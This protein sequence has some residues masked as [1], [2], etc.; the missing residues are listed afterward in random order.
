ML[1]KIAKSTAGF[2][3]I[4]QDSNKGKVDSVR[5]WRLAYYLR[6][7]KEM[8]K[9]RKYGR[10]FAEEIIEEYRQ[11]VVHNLTGRNKDNNIRNI[12][13]IPVATRL[14]EMETKV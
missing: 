7:V 10:E 11:I 14:A 12:M 8:D 2:K 9:K 13:I 5:F 6:E 1:Y 4:L 3:I